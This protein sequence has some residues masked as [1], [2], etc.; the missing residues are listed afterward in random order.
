VARWLRRRY[1]SAH[2]LSL[3]WT[4]GMPRFQTRTKHFTLKDLDL[5]C[6]RLG[7]R[8]FATLYV[9]P[10]RRARRATYKKRS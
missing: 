8:A 1:S 3:V 5:E 4:T 7:S 2:P 10:D 6:R 9:A